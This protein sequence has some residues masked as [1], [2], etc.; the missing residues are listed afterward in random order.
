MPCLLKLNGVGRF[1]DESAPEQAVKTLV[2]YFNRRV[3]DDEL[4]AIQDLLS[5]KLKGEEDSL[6]IEW[7]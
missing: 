3:T 2:L 1:V 5:R 4:C 6:H 7:D